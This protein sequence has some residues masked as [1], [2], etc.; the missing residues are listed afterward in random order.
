MVKPQNLRNND[1]RFGWSRDLLL[2]G[3]GS[4]A[5]VF[6]SNLLNAGV[7]DYYMVPTTATTVEAAP[8]SSSSSPSTIPPGFNP[9]YSY[10]GK[11]DHLFETIGTNETK[12]KWWLATSPEHRDNKLGRWFSQHGQ[13]IA[14]AKFFGFQRDGFFV[15]LA[16]NDAVW[17][18]NTFL[19]E[20]NF[21]WKGICIE[22]NPI[23]WYRLS[24]RNCHVVGGIVGGTNNQEVNVVLGEAHH[25][26]FGG[27]VG[28][29]FDNKKINNPV[30]RYTVSLSTILDMFDAPKVIDYLSLDVEGAETYIMRDFPFDK[31]KFKCMSVER[32]KDELLAL[33]ENNGYKKV[34]DFK[35]G[36][37]LW[38]HESVYDEG[39]KRTD[40]N[41]Q[42]ITNKALSSEIPGF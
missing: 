21:G 9:I 35:R 2:L 39:K 10:F 13:D 12:G 16:A 29:D 17:A 36:D 14:V 1:R 27:I 23:Y 8:T 32:P 3:A 31:Y 28:K 11:L 37:T 30:K 5:G 18:S 15:D 22:A 20:Q 38:A 41:A 4:I 25:G 24:F 19:L 34:R 33:L 6:L 40:L 42:E 7:G 26:P